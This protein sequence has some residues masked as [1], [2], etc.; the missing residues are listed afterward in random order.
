MSPWLFNLYMD[1]IVTEAMEKFVGEYSWNRLWYSYS[2]SQM[3]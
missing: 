3:I 1:N 2:Y